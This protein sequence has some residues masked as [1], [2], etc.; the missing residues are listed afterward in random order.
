MLAGLCQCLKGI[1]QGC[2]AGSYCQGCA[3]A[4]KGSDTLFKDI[5]CRVCQTSVDV[6]CITKSESVSS[7]LGI[8]EYIGCGCIDRYGSGIRY[9]ICLFLSDVQL[10]CFKSPVFRIFNIFSHDGNLLFYTN[11]MLCRSLFPVFFQFSIFC[12]M[13]GFCF[14]SYSSVQQHIRSLLMRTAYIYI[15]VASFVPVKIILSQW[16]LCV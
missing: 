14:I 12:R 5:L 10:S 6:T 11:F 15:C 3:A 8:V 16:G 7:M 2:C 13:C 1:R 4:F 9:R